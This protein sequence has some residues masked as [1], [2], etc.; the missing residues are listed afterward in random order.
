[1]EHEDVQVYSNDSGWVAVPDC[2]EQN[3]ELLDPMK[4]KGIFDQLNDYQILQT[5]S[6]M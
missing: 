6:P 1:M 4:G 3:N 5:S 2:F